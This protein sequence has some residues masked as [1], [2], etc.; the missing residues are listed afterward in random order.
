MSGTIGE[1]TYPIFRGQ[2]VAAADAV[3]AKRRL[4]RDGLEYR[5][6]G[7]EEADSTVTT[8]S[9]AVDTAANTLAD[10]Q[11]AL[12]GQ[13][14]SITDAYGVTHA[15]CLIMDVRPQITACVSAVGPEVPEGANR[16]ITTQWTI[17]KLASQ[18]G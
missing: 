1:T 10:A 4:G 18:G 3:E 17:R 5:I 6:S 8:T 2:A 11:R 16:R 12:K 13:V 7:K 15:K 14:V 9:F